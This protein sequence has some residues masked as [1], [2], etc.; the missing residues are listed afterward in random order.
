MSTTFSVT[1]MSCTGC[2]SNVEAAVSELQGIQGVE[3]DHEAGTV[4]VDGD[5]DEGTV[6][7]AIE[8]SGYEV[9]A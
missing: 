7:S 6:T 8:D 2:E 1:G 5:V 4:T 3:A 9:V